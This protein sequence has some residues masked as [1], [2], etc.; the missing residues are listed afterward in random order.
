MEYAHTAVADLPQNARVAR[1]LAAC[2]L[3]TIIFASFRLGGRPVP[4]IALMPQAL[5]AFLRRLSRKCR[6]R[7]SA[8]KAGRLP[9]SQVFQRGQRGHRPARREGRP[10]RIILRWQGCRMG[11]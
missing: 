3:R 10:G 4:P 8:P 5:M 6:L 7:A 1:G 9:C 11:S 2:R